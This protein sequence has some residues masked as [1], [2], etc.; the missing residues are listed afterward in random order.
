MIKP[1]QGPGVIALAAVFLALNLFFIGVRCYTKARISKNFNYNDVGMLVVVATYASLM[2]L[3]ILGVEN[4]IGTHTTSATLVEI[5][6]SLKYIWFLEF[7]YVILTSIM[8]ASIATTLLQWSRSRL[9]T[10]IL[11]AA[12]AADF[13]IALVF[14][15]YLILQ[16]RPVSYAW[17]FINPLVKGKCA[18]FVGQLYMGYALCI[19]T[20]TLDMIFLFLPF[21]MLKG[22]GVNKTLK[23]YT[24]GI[25]GLGVLASIANFIRLAA[26]VKLKGSKDQLFDA[27][28]VFAW[29]IVEV[30]IGICVAG[31]LELGPLMRRYNVKGFESY[32]GQ[33]AKMGDDTEPLKLQDMGKGDGMGFGVHE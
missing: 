15:L 18:P 8:K 3:L 21:V 31:I 20:I 26:L 12:I 5:G 2:A 28:P 22:R 24:Y 14:C 23:L 30:S 4:G 9:H 6:N 10:A 32:S 11:W 25:F 16:C 1:G 19:V 33:F 29:S 27:S 13:T 17:T 7:I